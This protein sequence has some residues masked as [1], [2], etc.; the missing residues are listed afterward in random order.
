MTHVFF[1]SDQL[2]WSPY[3]KNQ[4]RGEG[5]MMGGRDDE[6]EPDKPLFRGSRY[7]RGFGVKSAL[8][9]IGR[10][11]LP[12]ASNIMDSA[13]DEASLSLGRLGADLAQGKPVADTIKQHA[14]TAGQNFASRLQQCGKGK[15]RSKIVNK[16]ALANIGE[17]I[18]EPITSGPNP[19]PK[20][21]EGGK[22]K[23]GR[24]RDYLDF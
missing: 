8:S 10:F 24:K 2:D 11:L 21:T 22:K 5:I 14:R 12:I 7:Q 16:L 1:D 4:Q 3:L 18:S 17:Q 9:S 13:K 15:K 6:I 23:R 19:I 20:S